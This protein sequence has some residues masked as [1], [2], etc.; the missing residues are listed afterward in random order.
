[1]PASNSQAPLPASCME[2]FS[3]LQNRSVIP[4][5][6]YWGYLQEAS[7][8]YLVGIFENNNL[9]VICATC[10]AVIPKVSQLACCRSIEFK[11]WLP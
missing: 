3:G 11:N 9:I 7:D 5:S 10:V 8:T 6:S 1:M 2:N 4:E